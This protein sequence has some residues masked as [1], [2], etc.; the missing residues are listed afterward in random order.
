MTNLEK[1]VDALI[2]VVLAD[3]QMDFKR[4]TADLMVLSVN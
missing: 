3:N 1:K 2:R 4:A